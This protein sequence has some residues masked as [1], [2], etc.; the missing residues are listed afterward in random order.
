MMTKYFIGIDGGGTRCRA[1]LEDAHGK[2]LGQG[3]GGA[4]NIMRNPAQATTSIVDACTR[5]VAASTLPVQLKEITVGAGLA[6]ANIPSA[7]HA[8]S[9]WQHPFDS[10]SV[11]SD[12]HAACL[13]AHDG[14]DG[15]VIVCGTGSS[16][17]RCVN[18]EFI[19]IGGHGFLVGDIAS[20]A[21]LGLK[22]VQ[23]T[24]LA[25]DGL[26][27]RDPLCEAVC[28]TFDVQDD[29]ALIQKVS[30][31]E[32]KDYAVLAPAMVTLNT[33]GD[34]VARSLFDEGSA[35]L[36]RIAHHLLDNSNLPLCLIGGLSDTYKPWYDESVR[37]RIQPCKS[38]P[39][40]GAI[41]FAKQS[42]K[43]GAQQL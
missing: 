36:R 17:T 39:E 11:L 8:F 6:G 9:N 25:L 42:I 14:Q 28:A 21:W 31:F 29:S 5:A 15:A 34:A 10:L 20:G 22:A 1:R 23:H 38:S 43:Q 33:D 4:A 41:A 35:Y 18:G 37:A 16:A 13:G 12:L 2:L 32:A 27:P 30:A 3:E 19:D 7:C 24:L 26:I 40:Q